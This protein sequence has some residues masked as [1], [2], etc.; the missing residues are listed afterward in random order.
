MNQLVNQILTGNKTVLLEHLIKMVSLK[1]SMNL[2]LLKVWDLWKPVSIIIQIRASKEELRDVISNF[3]F[4]DAPKML[5]RGSNWL[6]HLLQ[7]ITWLLSPLKPMTVGI[8]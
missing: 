4:M 5:K 7:Q 3:F 8:W 1:K 6:H 2:T